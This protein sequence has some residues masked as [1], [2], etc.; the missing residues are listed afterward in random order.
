MPSGAADTGG[1]SDQEPT[2]RLPII[3]LLAAVALYAC[4]ASPG[5]APDTSP[6]EGVILKIERAYDD[7]DLEAV[8][9]LRDFEAEAFYLLKHEV[10][11]NI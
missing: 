3:C 6:P 8:I 1:V 7:G 11:D 4:G 9:A 5:V 10:G 2:M